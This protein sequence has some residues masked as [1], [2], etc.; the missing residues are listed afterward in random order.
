ML[1]LHDAEEI[2]RGGFGIV[3]RYVESVLDRVVAVKVLTRERMEQRP[4]TR[5]ARPAAPPTALTVAIVR[6]LAD[7]VT[8]TERTRGQVGRRVGAVTT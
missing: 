1:G 6:A 7:Y 4:L 3:F 8:E 5:F 2:G